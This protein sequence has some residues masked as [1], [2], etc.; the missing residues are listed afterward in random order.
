MA[1]RVVAGAGGALDD[2]RDD[3]KRTADH[4]AGK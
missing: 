2:E 4:T 1:E 3:E